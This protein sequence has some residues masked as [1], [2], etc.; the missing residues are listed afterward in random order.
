MSAA[1][2]PRKPRVAEASGVTALMLLFFGWEAASG[3]SPGWV[4]IGCGLLALWAA[5][6]LARFA[7]WRRRTRARGPA[8]N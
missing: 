2:G 1:P 6:E 5:V 8:R 4:R 7:V 3:G